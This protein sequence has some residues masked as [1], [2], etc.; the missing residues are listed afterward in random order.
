MAPH[1]AAQL[2]SLTL[3]FLV[4][5]S[6]S[7]LSAKQPH[8][9]LQRHQIQCL[10]KSLHVLEPTETIESEGGTTEFWDQKNEQ[11]LCIGVAAIRYTIKP[12]GLLLPLY[13]NG[14]RVHY[15]LQGKGIQ[16]TIISGCPETFSSSSS[17]QFQKI[18]YIK[19]G[20]VIAVP[21]GSAQ[22]IY[23][24]GNSDLILFSIVDTANEDNQLDVKVR[25][26]FLAGN[27]QG[28]Q[29]NDEKQSHQNWRSF[30]QIHLYK[31]QTDDGIA[32]TNVFSGM[33]SDLVS[34]TFGIDAELTAKVKGG[35]DSRGSMVIVK[36]GL[37]LLTPE[38]EEEEEE[39]EKEK[40]RRER[41]KGMVNGL[42]ET[43]CTMRLVHQLEEAA[44]ADK[45]NPKAGHLTGLNTPNLPVLEHLQLGV[46]LGV[47]YKDAIMV[48]HY[49]LN[50][51]AIIY[52]TRGSAWIQVVADNGVQVFDGDLKKG[53]VLIVPQHYVVVKKGGPDGFQW[54][55]IKT[56]DNPMINPLA[57]RLS[58]I[59]AMP[60]EVL[61][62]AFGI[63][64]DEAQGLK[65]REELT[66]LSPL[67]D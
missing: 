2:L 4:V 35:N 33:A 11:I 50:C 45:Y 25:K 42:E 65:K 27:P 44:D 3:I 19:M 22:W 48:P 17:D 46:D 60:L 38:M 32:G 58:L 59:R 39:K 67:Y 47:L 53:Q 56:S 34:Q 21:S 12:K 5:F 36:D 29:K 26:F 62:A 18:H 43:I 37:D 31:G 52:C 14:P 7:C 10:L 57:G 23:N 51:H 6:R 28:E 64:K 8:Q 16:E 63:D 40:E 66:L 54:V 15:V 61:M 13:V 55:A 20:D 49:N 41:E 9:Q 1:S 30:G 24:T